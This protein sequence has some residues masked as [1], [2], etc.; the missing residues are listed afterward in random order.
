[1]YDKQCNS[2]L[3]LKY[4][5]EG[6]EIR[7]KSKAP[8]LSCVA[9]LTNVACGYIAVGTFDEALNA[10]DEAEELLLK[11]RFPQ[12]HYIAYLNDTRGKLYLK[13]G[14]MDKAAELFEKAALGREKVA[15]GSTAHV[16]SL[17]NVMKVAVKKG[18]MINVLKL[19]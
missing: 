3:A 4:F 8:D 9:S 5:Q 18:T 11:Q 12:I 16:E 15:Y 6:I 14:N 19:R 7:K 10:L 17:V 2:R 1:M 13:Q